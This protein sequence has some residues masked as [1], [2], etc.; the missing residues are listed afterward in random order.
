MSVIIIGN[1]E[2]IMTRKTIQDLLKEHDIDVG[3][4]LWDCRGKTIVLH[5]AL[6]QL[7]TALDI[8]FEPPVLVESNSETGRVVMLVRGM[9][10]NEKDE[11]GNA[12][13]GRIEWTFG[14]ASPQNNKNPYPYAMAEKRAKDRVILKLLGVHGEVYS[15][16]EAD[17][18]RKPS[19]FSKPTQKSTID[20]PFGDL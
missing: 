14:E 9:L 11:N 18:F 12:I 19:K 6:E 4:A 20:D 1:Q 5:K 13:K 16:V 8:G 15:D 10:P 2:E 7:A 17:D 3:T